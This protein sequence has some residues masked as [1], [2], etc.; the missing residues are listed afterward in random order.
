MKFRTVA[1]ALAIGVLTL[2][3][4]GPAGRP[5]AASEGPKPADAPAK[6]AAAAEVVARAQQFAA[7]QD[8]WAAVCGGFAVEAGYR[9]HY[10]EYLTL[11]KA[12]QF[13]EARELVCALLDICTRAYGKDHYETRSTRLLLETVGR[14]AELPDVKRAEFVKTIKRW[15]DYAA[16]W[17]KGNYA[18]AA[19]V[20][21]EILEVRRRLLRPEDLAV[22]IN[23]YAYALNEAGKYAEADPYYREAL[24]ICRR[25]VGNDHPATAA[26][27]GN[28]AINLND[29][30][31][32]AE[33]Q[34]FLEE[35]MKIDIRLFGE[36]HPTTALARN[37]LG[38]NLDKQ[39]KHALAEP[40]LRR[41][42][43]V[44][45]RAEGKD[46]WRAVTARG[47]LAHN[48]N[49]QGK[50]DAAEPLYRAVLETRLN[51]PDE[52]PLSL[53]ASSLALVRQ[54]V[55]RLN[56]PEIA[57][58]Y[59]NLA[60][61]LDNQG[62]YAA[63]ESLHRQALTMYQAFDEDY[64]FAGLT[65]SN[66]AVNLNNQGRYEDAE[67]YYEKAQR[68]FLKAQKDKIGEKLARVYSNHG[69][70][71]VALGRVAEA[72]KLHEQALATFRG[73]WGN[74]HE[75]VAVGY[76]NLG[77]TLS[78]QDKF[79]EAEPLIRE[80]VAIHEKTLGP[81][82]PRTTS[83]RITLAINLQ[84]QGNYAEAREPLERGLEVHGRLLGEGHPSTTWA[85]K[86]LIINA[87]GRGDYRKAEELGPAAAAS[88]E[89][90]RRRVSHTGLGRVGHSDEYSPLLFLVAA[91]ARNGHEAAA[92]GYLE[93]G[94]ARG[95][96][97]DL[98][99]RTLSVEE[100][101][102]EEGLLLQL[103]RL[104]N[105]LNTLLTGPEVSAEA[106][107]KADEV[108]RERA[109]TNA[110]LIQLRETLAA[111]HGV[112]AGDV[113]RLSRIQKSLQPG[114]ALLAWLDLSAEPKAVD[115][116]GDHWACLVKHTGD[117]VWVRLRGTGI[118]GAWTDKDD[119]L[120]N[121][122]RESISV[123]QPKENWKELAGKLANQ[124]LEGIKHLVVLPSARMKG[125]PV[126]VLTGLTVSYAP[127]GTMF[128]WLREKRGERGATPTAN[129]L[130]AF[131]DPAFKKGGDGPSD[132]PGS[133]QELAGI[134]RVFNRV[135]EFKGSDASEQNLDQ[136]AAEDGGL[137]R[138]GYLHFAT[139]GLLD[140]QRPMRSALLLAQDRL[141]DPLKQVLDGKEAYDGRLTAERILRRWNGK[142]DAELV[143][144]SACQTGLGKYSGGE[145]YL[146]FSQALFLAGARSLVV[147][148]WE[149]D[150]TA[151]S[152]L[153]TR[154]YENLMGLRKEMPGGPIE[155]KPKAEALAEAK[156]WL[157]KLTAEQ[158]DQLAEGLP[159][160]GTRGRVM[161]KGPVTKSAPRFD[162]PYYW[163]GFILIGDPR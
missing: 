105:Q 76:N 118:A 146:G 135:S 37:N 138:F 104:D 137:R 161:K 7:A 108:R 163:S 13:A 149:V 30:E 152:L 94:L 111:K 95:L 5:T 119:R 107:K 23:V 75:I 11:F 3:L 89:A 71:L 148:L 144:L 47:N 158:V 66:L 77:H 109:T 50:Y 68:I 87:I 74:S 140:D 79:A 143:T 55:Q 69:G 56:H 41:V 33:A 100:R 157:S 125:V 150:D 67:E 14:V 18:E 45:S 145:G 96:F 34:P 99:P 58:A 101:A 42:L 88:F 17:E 128:A 10:V 153:M 20:A 81:E 61:N 36:D 40:E 141:P 73:L 6:S 124:R 26:L 86:H 12:G 90:A 154:F 84:Q 120:A 46:S 28:L 112:A 72:Q 38:T 160:Q 54:R 85:Y 93:S 21:G 70:N 2:T 65:A 162:H 43:D 52:M 106:R 91:A 4:R 115:A 49:A 8:A 133:R 25:V 27:C 16:A 121:W 117:P 98:A 63:A 151:T 15:Q 139:H 22:D 92:W 51:P 134:G 29:R 103:D 123:R 9:Q 82:H 132:L 80:S 127:S 53:A 44:L 156:Q 142:L 130:L 136:L 155:P 57:R 102:A 122:V 60:V 126:E 39:G 83:A 31:L 24:E 159:R 129:H 48:L 59:A 110:K 97:D 35:A 113:Y 131:A 147:S 62:R 19:R 1:A 78:K 32:Y 114:E 64:I 116:N